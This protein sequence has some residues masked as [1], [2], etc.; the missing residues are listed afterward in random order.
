MPSWLP[1]C[2]KRANPAH[3]RLKVAELGVRPHGANDLVLAE[4]APGPMDSE[5]HIFAVPLDMDDDMV[6]QTP[7]DRLPITVWSCPWPATRRGYPR[8]RP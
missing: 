8:P 1:P 5:L 3:E 2:G 6:Y 7:D 4:G